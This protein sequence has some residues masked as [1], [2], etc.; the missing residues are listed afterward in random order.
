M[1]AEDA[2]SRAAELF[3]V[4]PGFPEVTLSWSG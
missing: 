3:G 2:R 4:Q 1:A